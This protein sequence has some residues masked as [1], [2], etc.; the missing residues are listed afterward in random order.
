MRLLKD[1]HIRSS[2]ETEGLRFLLGNLILFVR[3]ILIKHEK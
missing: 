3:T 2:W 1:S